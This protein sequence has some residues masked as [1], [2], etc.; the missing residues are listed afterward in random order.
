M[1]LLVT[2]SGP[3]GAAD[4][5]LD[6][7]RPVSELLERITAAMGEPGRGCRLRTS[8]GAEIRPDT[9][10]AEAGVLDGQRLTLVVP[11]PQTS[12]G[13]PVLACYVAVDT[14]DS[15]AGPALDMI[16][17]ELSRLVE[18]ARGD[19]RLRDACLLA[20]ATFDADV[21]LHLPLTPFSGLGPAPPL[22]ATRPATNLE[23]LFRFLRGQIAHDLTRLRAEGRHPLRPAVFLLTDGRPTRGHWQA[24]HADLTDRS[25]PDAPQIVVFG[26]GDYAA[27]AVRRIGTAGVHLPASAP[28]SATASPSPSP[29]G[30]AGMLRTLMTFMLDALQGSLPTP[31]EAPDPYGASPW[32]I[33]SSG[34]SGAASGWRPLAEVRRP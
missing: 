15:M 30:P 8:D 22:T 10:L 29:G 17:V 12:T 19:A 14:S 5:E 6:D 1:T 9:T 2:V 7:A 28:Q 13:A 23:A 25:W 34:P 21:R 18:A 32:D 3:G 11:A 31:Q 16:S 27:L 33:Q 24:A 20:V 4:L 26:S